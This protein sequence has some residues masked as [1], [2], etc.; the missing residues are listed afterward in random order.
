[1]ENPRP[2]WFSK[3]VATPVTS[4]QVRVDGHPVHYLDWGSPDDHR[5]GLILV[6]GN[7]ANARWWS[8]IAPLFADFRVVAPDL[9]GCGDTPARTAYSRDIYAD[10]LAAVMDHARLGE[11]P[12]MVAHSWGGFMALRTAARDDIA[13]GGLVLADSGVRPPDDGFAKKMA[14]IP[15]KPKKYYAEREEL[16]RRFK[17]RPPQPVANTYIADFLG[18]HSLRKEGDGWAWKHDENLVPKTPV[19]GLD[20]DLMN[21]RCRLAMIWGEHSY[22]RR[23]QVPRYMATLL[24]ADVP[25]IEIPDAYHHL[26]IDQPLAAVSALRAVFAGW[27]G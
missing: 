4:R 15:P 6:H 7:A 13:L 21:C 18:D 12:F 25:R 3:A 17:I 11:D 14:S 26:F 1:M 5:P 24:P 27:Q 10:E 2:E 22:F 23:Q 9:S 19:E 20:D 8:H 16:R